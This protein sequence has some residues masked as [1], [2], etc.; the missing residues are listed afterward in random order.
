ML[1]DGGRQKSAPC[2]GVEPVP[3]PVLHNSATQRSLENKLREEE[4]RLC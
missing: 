4:K 3:K 1:T 2:Q